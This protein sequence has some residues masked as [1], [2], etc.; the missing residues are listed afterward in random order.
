MGRK[1]SYITSSDLKRLR[2]LLE[3]TRE[4]H[5][6]N[7]AYLAKL[8]IEIARAKIVD[9]EDAPK[10]LI[11]MNCRV[12]VRDIDTREVEIYRLVYPGNGNAHEGKVSIFAPV[13]AALLGKRAGDIIKVEVP[14]GMRR[15]RVEEVLHEPDAAG[16][17]Q[18]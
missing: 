18:L 15:V 14:V 9:T 1:K 4:F 8:E 7:D 10:D 11:I 3:V 13:G 5:P 6:E 16:A 12:R 17:S 2:Q